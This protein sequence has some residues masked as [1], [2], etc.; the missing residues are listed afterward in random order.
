MFAYSIHQKLFLVFELKSVL[1]RMYLW[2]CFLP[3]T[4]RNKFSPFGQKECPRQPFNYQ[5]SWSCFPTFNSL[6]FLISGTSSST[7][8]IHFQWEVIFRHLTI[9]VTSPVSQLSFIGHLCLH[10]PYISSLKLC[11]YYN[12]VGINYYHLIDKETKI[13]SGNNLPKITQIL[14]DRTG[15]Q[16]QNQNPELLGSKFLLVNHQDT[17]CL[18]GL[19][20]N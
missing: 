16:M 6:L 11:N 12:E 1:L 10:F 4:T 9:P 7:L 2:I 20:S 5:R 14:R 8:L 15:V 3:L 19:W 18:A 13:Q 17:S